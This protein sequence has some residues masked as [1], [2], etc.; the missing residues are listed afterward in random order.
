MKYLFL[1]SVV[2]LGVSAL[3]LKQNNFL[4]EMAPEEVEEYVNTAFPNNSETEIE[5]LV[6]KIESLTEE[7]AEEEGIDTAPIITEEVADDSVIGLVE[8]VIEVVETPVEV[9]IV[10]ELAEEVPLIVEDLDSMAVEI[11]LAETELVIQMEELV[12]E[13][14]KVQ[15]ADYIDQFAQMEDLLAENDLAVEEFIYDAKDQLALDYEARDDAVKSAEQLM[16][17]YAK[18]AITEGEIVLEE[19]IFDMQEQHDQDFLALEEQIPE[20][21][22]VVEE[23]VLENL[24]EDVAEIEAELREELDATMGEYNALEMETLDQ[25]RVGID[26]AIAVQKEEWEAILDQTSL[27]TADMLN[28]IDINNQLVKDEILLLFQSLQE[29]IEALEDEEASK[30]EKLSEIEAIVIE[31]SV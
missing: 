8:A 11:Q 10:D 16:D 24:Y 19:A 7:E 28:Q 1:F 14:L 21:L 26:E 12:D 22:F 17:E 25:I 4:N 27:D 15:D 20:G 9:E 3:A 23:E 31:L 6:E 13:T 30:A 2:L 29:K 18:I 5:E